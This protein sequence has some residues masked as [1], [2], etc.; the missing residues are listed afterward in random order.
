MDPARVAKR[1]ILLG[2]LGRGTSIDALAA[3]L[4]GRAPAHVPMVGEAEIWPLGDTWVVRVHE[5]IPQERAD[6]LVGHELAEWWADRE[7]VTFDSLR[8]RERWCDAVGAELLR[9]LRVVPKGGARL[10]SVA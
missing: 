1:L 7:G 9:A 6:A 4:L 5:R 3:R 8:E 10:F 2:A